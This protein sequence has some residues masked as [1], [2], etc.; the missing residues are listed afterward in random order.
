[1]PGQGASRETLQILRDRNAGM[2]KFRSRQVDESLLEDADLIIAM[3]DSHA[4]MV[5]RVFPGGAGRVS[6]LCDFLPGDEEE[7]AGADVPDP[8]GMGR[9]AYEDVA[10]IISLAIPGILREL[11]ED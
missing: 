3:T 8:I 1:M 4:A 9:A 10:E 11:E 7:L 2:E 5:R 6:L